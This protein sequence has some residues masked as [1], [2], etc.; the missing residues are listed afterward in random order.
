MSQCSVI[1]DELRIRKLWGRGIESGPTACDFYEITKRCGKGTLNA[2]GRIS[3]LRKRGHRI[4][5]KNFN[6]LDRYYL[7]YDA[8][9]DAPKANY[10]PELKAAGF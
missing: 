4:S 1:L 9:Q 5:C 3:E 7:E 10:S 6:G 8:E 2:S